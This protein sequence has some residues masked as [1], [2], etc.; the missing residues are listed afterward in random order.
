MICWV[1]APA[2]VQVFAPCLVE[3]QVAREATS[4]LF[5]VGSCLIEGKWKAAK[6]LDNGCSL[7]REHRRQ[8]WQVLHL[9]A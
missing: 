2:L 1:L 3:F 7:E 6:G 8:C 9:V 4:G 5:D